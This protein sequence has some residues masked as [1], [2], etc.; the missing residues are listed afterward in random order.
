MCHNDANKMTPHPLPY[1]SF[2]EFCKIDNFVK[3][4]LNICIIANLMVGSGERVIKEGVCILH[5]ISR[6]SGGV[7]IGRVGFIKVRVGII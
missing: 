3:S 6:F 4:A 7:N 2:P 5:Q 1:A